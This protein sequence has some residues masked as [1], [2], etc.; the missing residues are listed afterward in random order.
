MAGRMRIFFTVIVLFVAAVAQG[1]G[2]GPHVSGGHLAGSA[3]G[4]DDGYS[5]ANAFVPLWQPN[6]DSLLFADGSFLLFNDGTDF[7]GGN[8]GGG[9]RSWQDATSSIVGVYGYYDRRELDVTSFDQYGLGI[10][11]LGY[12]WDARLNVNVPVGDATFSQTSAPGFIGTGF[13]TR[14]TSIHG[15]T[16]LDAEVGAVLWANESWQFRSFVGAYGLFDNVVQ[17]TP[18]VR[19][20]IEARVNDQCWIGGFIEHDR[21]FDTTGGATF[22]WRFGRGKKACNNSGYNVLARLGDPVSRR[23]YVALGKSE[24]TTLATVQGEALEIAH[25]VPGGD[26]LTGQSVTPSGDGSV[27]KPYNSLA[28]VETSTADIVYIHPGVYEGASMRVTREG[29]RVVGGSALV[30]VILGNTTRLLPIQGVT[31]LTNSPQDAITI[32]A[33]GVQVEGFTIVSPQRHGIYG[34]DVNGLLIGENTI[35]GSGDDG[36]RLGITHS[37]WVGGNIVVSSGGAGLIAQSFEGRLAYNEFNG[38]A[39]EGVLIAGPAMASFASNEF[40]NN[41][42]HGLRVAGNLDSY[43]GFSSLERNTA[44]RNSGDGLRVEGNLESTYSN[45]SITW[46][47]SHNNAGAGIRI[48]GGVEGAIDVNA[49][50]ENGDTGLIVGGNVENLA[51]NES[52]RN[53]GRGILIGGSVGESGVLPLRSIEANAAHDNEETGIEI[54]GDLIGDLRDSYAYRNDGHGVFVH[55]DVAGDLLWSDVAAND[56]TG[57]RVD[58]SVVG[59]VH[60]NNV[61]TNGFNTAEDGIHIG[62]NVGGDVINNDT[63]LNGDDGIDID[64]VVSGATSPNFATGNGDQAFEN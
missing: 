57:V 50:H 14:T 53:L 48:G 41:G 19:S 20:R 24:R 59:S 45:N 54:Q 9:V 32:S 36:I 26:G 8:V 17:D 7:L 55:G 60:E 49:T 22:T 61:F 11:S 5:E 58:G 40:H 13:G 29:Q 1:Q 6:R 27:E 30:G 21:E 2:V 56:L 46:N 15:L 38:N 34:A 63:Y 42:S 10:E 31:T 52:N 51:S 12:I 64:G 44:T 33:D 35:S 16:V 18:G 28:F 4:L 25:F 39:A 47:Q 43:Q 3:A 37:A 23:K 62:G